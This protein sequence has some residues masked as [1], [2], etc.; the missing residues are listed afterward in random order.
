ML[1]VRYLCISFVLL[2]CSAPNESREVI[3]QTVSEVRTK[4]RVVVQ[5]RLPD[6][7]YPSDKD[8]QL[9]QSIEKQIEELHIGVIAGQE[10]GP[11]RMDMTIEVENTVVAIPR[12]QGL[13]RES[14]VLETSTI[15]VA[16]Q[17]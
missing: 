11:G 10:S 13:L 7:G 1:R 14:G 15:R 5:I 12:I 3:K 8:L 16:T 17:T 2:A 9:R 6:N 4:Q